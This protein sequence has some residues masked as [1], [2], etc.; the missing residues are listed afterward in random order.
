M[1]MA[2]P[3]CPNANERA[4]IVFS[5]T[6]ENHIGGVLF[7]FVIKV[8]RMST[9]QATIPFK[10]RKKVTLTNKINKSNCENDEVLNYKSPRKRHAEVDV[11]FKGLCPVVKLSRLEFSKWNVLKEDLSSLNQLK[12]DPVSGISNSTKPLSSR[13]Q[14]IEYLENFLNRQLDCKESASIY[15]SGQPGTGKTASLSYIL[16]LPKV[17]KGYKQVYINCTMM[18]SART[19]YN[20]I[21]QELHLK[22]SGTTE[23]ACLSAIEKY[24]KKDHKMT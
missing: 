12:E 2:S 21:C 17:V 24:L 11:D 9:L 18:K 5:L 19:I 8:S 6:T 4:R 16:K 13:E 23:K 10:S 7:L 22:T 3:L 15:I 14:E 20:R 1:I